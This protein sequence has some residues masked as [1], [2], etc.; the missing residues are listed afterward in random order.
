MAENS[1]LFGDAKATAK[2]FRR[3]GSNSEL[4]A[5]RLNYETDRSNPE[6]V[7]AYA[8]ALNSSNFLKEAYE[9]YREYLDSFPATEDVHSVTQDIYF[10]M[11]LI[12]KAIGMREDAQGLFT[13]VVE[14]G[15]ETN[16][17]RSAEYELWAL[18][19]RSGQRWAK[20]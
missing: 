8:E 19:G 18:D 2:S 17:A 20:Q 10:E 12:A 9:V 13:K 3:N 1:H 4:D 15:P 6:T 14:M 11:A 7:I 5:A 16:L